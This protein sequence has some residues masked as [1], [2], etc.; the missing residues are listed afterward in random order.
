LLLCFRTENLSSQHKEAVSNV[1]ATPIDYTTEDFVQRI[2]TLTGDG[3]DAVFDPIGGTHLTGSFKTLRK[4]GRLVA[5]GFYSVLK[6]GRNAVLD[7]LSQ[8]VRVALW[9]VAPNGKHAAFYSIEDV[10]KKHPAWFR[11]DLLTLLD[12]LAKGQIKPIIAE[13]L[14][15]EDVVHAHE[16]LENAEVQGKLVLIP[17][18]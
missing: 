13:R 18:P 2:F 6:R 1:G 12:L 14:P 15:L 4:G 10:K 11:E 3:V 8:F 9:N 16:L 5:Y 7:I 17:N